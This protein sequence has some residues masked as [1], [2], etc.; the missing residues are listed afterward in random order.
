MDF[1]YYLEKF[2]KAAEEIDKKMLREKPLNIYIVVTLNSVVL[3]LGWSHAS[4]I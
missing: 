2:R 4:L 3:K 1:E